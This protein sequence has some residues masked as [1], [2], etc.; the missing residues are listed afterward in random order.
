MNK[1]TK[2]LPKRILL[3]MAMRW[4]LSFTFVQKVIKK[5]LLGC[6][7]STNF[8]Y[9]FECQFW[10]IKAHNV[11]LA[12]T[13]CNDHE[14]IVI[15]EGTKFSSGNRI[16]TW[17]HNIYDFSI[18]ENK[19]VTIWKNC[20]ITTGVI[21]LPGVTIWDN[22]IIGAWSIVTKDIPSYSLAVWNPCKSIKSLDPNKFVYH[23]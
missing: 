2:Q 6:T 18:C 11:W 10:N 1:Q 7:G 23:E 21:I 20:R 14:M 13:I 8:M 12:D 19:P 3:L 17:T 15:W 5:R 16:I 4:P 9:G 22:C